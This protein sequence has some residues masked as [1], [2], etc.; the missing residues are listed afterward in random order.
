M[1]LGLYLGDSIL[2]DS[3]AWLKE[4][5]RWPR[6]MSELATFNLPA[7][8]QASRSQKLPSGQWIETVIQT[9]SC[10]SF[11]VPSSFIVFDLYNNLLQRIKKKQPS[12]GGS[13]L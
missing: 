6:L 9:L 3:S 8:L 10:K 11:K 12:L 2:R 5:R 13:C 7:V 4:G 1:L